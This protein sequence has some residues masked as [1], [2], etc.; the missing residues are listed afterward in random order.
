MTVDKGS[1]S[2]QLQAF[3]GP[4]GEHRVLIIGVGRRIRGDESAGLMV[5]DEL[6][7]LK[8]REYRVIVAEDRPEN[9][10]DEIR[11]YNPTHILYL[12]AT[13]SGGTPG[14]TRLITIEEHNQMSLHESP[15]TTLTHY[16]STLLQTKT[17]LLL[18]E[19]KTV[20]GEASRGMET[21]AKR[22]SEEIAES[23]S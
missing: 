15:L 17:R 21:A 4:D 13:K 9:F 22:I 5:A 7:R 8:P 6:A 2:E 10:T 16:L 12:L 3:W 18:I 20:M 19:P 14:G 1:L 11:H 23:L